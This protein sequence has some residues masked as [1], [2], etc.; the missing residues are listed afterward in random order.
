VIADGVMIENV[1]GTKHDDIIRG[2]EADNI[3]EGLAG[4]DF[5]DGRGGS[6]TASYRMSGAG[7][8]VDLTLPGGVQDTTTAAD[9]SSGDKLVS[10]ENLIGSQHND[11]LKGNRD[12]NRLEGGGGNDT[13][14]GNAGKD[15]FVVEFAPGKGIDAITDFE[16]GVDSLV[17]QVATQVVANALDALIANFATNPQVTVTPSTTTLNLRMAQSTSDGLNITFSQAFQSIPT[18]FNEVFGDMD[19]F[20]VDVV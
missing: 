20:M 16:R 18:T 10:I 13:L 6:D 1:I 12:H 4:A 9:H 5:L 17:L 11:T 19:H 14:T 2:N 3:L 8:T 7:V 15:I